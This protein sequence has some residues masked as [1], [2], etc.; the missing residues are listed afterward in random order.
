MLRCLRLSLFSDTRPAIPPRESSAPLETLVLSSLSQPS[1]S[2]SMESFTFLIFVWVIIS[3]L[4]AYVLRGK[5]NKE[6]KESPFATPRILWTYLHQ[7]TPTPRQALC[8][9]SWRKHHP[10]PH[11]SLRILTPKTVYGYLHGLPD[12]RRDAPLLRDP[13]R[14]EEAVA[15]HALIEHG[16]VWLHPHT[17]LTQPLHA[18]L[19]PGRTEVAAFRYLRPP[20]SPSPTAPLFLDRRALAAPKGNPF[21]RRW[22]TE[23]MRLLAFP[24]VEA[25]LRSLPFPDPSPLSFLPS[26]SLAPDWVMTLALQHAL[27]IQPY[28][29]ESVHFHPVEEGPLR[30]QE[31]A[32][33][34]PKKEESLALSAWDRPMIFLP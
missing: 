1:R 31:D 4:I 15:L 18:W 10:A 6:A 23:Y 2:L 9:D 12:L 25:Y 14:W 17:R 7:E 16:G 32:R 22:Y 8:I 27:L 29:M 24:S 5:G 30:H 28:P 19:L 34:D 3:L 33:G 21:I 13:K 11:W 26:P 20:F